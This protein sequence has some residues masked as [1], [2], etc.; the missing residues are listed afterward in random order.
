M[1]V[2]HSS[3]SGVVFN[4][5]S[6]LVRIKE[7]VRPKVFSKSRYNNTFDDFRY[8]RKIRNVTVVRQLVLIKITF[9]RR[10]DIVDCLRV[11]WN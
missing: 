4:N 2:Q 5:V 9:V 11:G 7:I 10:G 6:R 3:F 8:K 1:N